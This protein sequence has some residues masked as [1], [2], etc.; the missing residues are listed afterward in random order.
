MKTKYIKITKGL[1][2]RITANGNIVLK[3]KGGKFSA[4]MT[5][6]Q[7]EFKPLSDM[8]DENGWDY[9]SIAPIGRML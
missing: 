1:F 6:K 7:D 2:Y 3:R 8:L 9:G 4:K 5:I